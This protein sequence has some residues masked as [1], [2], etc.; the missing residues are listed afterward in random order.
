MTPAPARL[1]RV[2]SPMALTSVAMVAAS[3]LA[4]VVLQRPYLVELGLPFLVV[5]AVGLLLDG[6]A[7][8]QATVTL[9]SERIL[10]DDSTEIVVVLQGYG[11]GGRVVVELLEP[12]GVAYAKETPALREVLLPADG[13]ALVRFRM[14]TPPWGVH[15]WQPMTVRVPA[16][17]G[18]VAYE[19]VVEVDA[20]LRVLPAA[21]T[22][23]RLARAS[24]TGIVAGSRV[25]AAKAE[26]FEFADIRAFVPGDRRRDVNWRAT[27]RRGE[28]RVNDRH[29]ERSTDV[30]LMIDA[31]PS[32]GLASAVR[33]TV[34]LAT[35][36]LGER[37]RVGLVRFGT[38]LEWLTPGMGARQLYRIV[39]VLLEASVLRGVAWESLRRLPNQALPSTALVIAVTPLADLYSM[40]AVTQI[41]AQGLRVAVVEIAA[42]SVVAPGP[43]PADQLAYA[44]WLL[45]LEENRDRFRD[46]GVP[47]VAWNIREPLAPVIE[48]VAAFQRYAR[49]RTG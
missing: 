22:L 36:Y 9:S 37:D 34:A 2:V 30:V 45:E 6:P 4:A 25:A 3:M 47:I 11:P 32:A 19:G 33:A 46:R 1:H 27:A 21:E 24:R 7:E 20:V 41:A 8:V 48:E 40:S 26:G 12:A 16:P 44:M 14:E 31:F 35:A 28:L 13:S 5:L 17:L 39:D 18:L 10:E 42:D 29:P 23:E 38:T 49:H 43:A 15:R